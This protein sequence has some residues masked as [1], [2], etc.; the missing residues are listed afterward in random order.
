MRKTIFTMVIGFASAIFALGGAR[1]AYA[2]PPT[3]AC[4][5]LTPAQV[6]AVLG[7]KVDAGTP[8][9]G[10]SKLC[11]WGAVVVMAKGTSKKGVT[12]TLQDPMAFTY[13]KMPAGQGIVK[14]PVS[15]IGDDAVYGTTPGFPTVLTVKKGD[16]VFVVHVNGFPDDQIKAKEKTLALDVLAKL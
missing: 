3:D 11:H 15:G 5:L 4:S 1:T 6:S 13:A 12:L 7:L 9:P 8:L 16:V 2:G 10:N 14:V